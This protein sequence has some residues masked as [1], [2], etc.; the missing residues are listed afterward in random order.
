MALSG[1]I[2]AN[3][4]LD[5]LAEWVEARSPEFQIEPIEGAASIRA[6]TVQVML[7]FFTSDPLN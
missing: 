2:T 6:A 5:G 7:R 4:T 1:V 3:R